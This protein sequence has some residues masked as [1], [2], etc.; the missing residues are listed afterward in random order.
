[1]IIP[2]THD[3]KTYL[4][5]NDTIEQV[6]L[7]Q[8]ID[9][10]NLTVTLKFL[11]TDKYDVYNIYK[12]AK[13]SVC[14]LWTIVSTEFDKYE[15]THYSCLKAVNYRINAH[16]EH[17]TIEEEITFTSPADFERFYDIN[18]CPSVIKNNY[19]GYKYSNKSQ[20]LKEEQAPVTEY[21]WALYQELDEAPKDAIYINTV[22]DLVT[23]T[24]MM[25]EYFSEP[26]HGY[27]TFFIKERDDIIGFDL[28]QSGECLV[29][30]LN[31]IYDRFYARTEGSVMWFKLYKNEE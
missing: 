20:E 23:F 15:I 8:G 14:K 28:T 12:N 5:L 13:V 21:N 4:Q 10:N 22:E 6:D 25:M 29:E 31:Y 11:K 17:Q 26:D 9:L 19:V 7:L 27:I 3:I 2:T 24:T 16:T 30:D 1:M 18:L